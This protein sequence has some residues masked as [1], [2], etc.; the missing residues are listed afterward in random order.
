MSDDFSFPGFDDIMRDVAAFRGNKDYEKALEKLSEAF[1]LLNNF[2]KH[3]ESLLFAAKTKEADCH[4]I[5]G[6]IFRRMGDWKSALESY[7][8]GAKLED[9]LHSGTYCRINTINLAITYNHRR[10]EDPDMENR[11]KDTIN[12][13]LKET[14]DTKRK[15]EWWAWADLAQT[16]LLYGK[17]EDAKQAY[18]KGR[19]TVPS[20]AELN[21]TYRVLCE[22][23]NKLKEIFSIRTTNFQEGIKYFEKLFEISTCHPQ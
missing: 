5:K 15:L 2:V 14:R 20:K 10:P 13:L 19:Y 16:L 1:I 4:G 7:E 18:Y 22:V 11:I 23:G 12:D 6:G 21:S 9:E 3:N 8:A 17:I